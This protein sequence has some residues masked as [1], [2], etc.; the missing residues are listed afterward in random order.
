MLKELLFSFKD[1]FQEKS[2]NPFIWTYFFVWCIRNWPLVYSLF[3][4]DDGTTLQSKVAFIS[5]YLEENPFLSN[6]GYNILYTLALLVVSYILLN[7]SRF[8]VNFSEKTIKPWVYKVTDKGSVVL[9]STYNLLVEQRD[10]TRKSLVAER[11]S[12]SKLEEQIK[13]LEK[14]YEKLASTNQELKA[15]REIDILTIVEDLRKKNLVPFYKTT[16]SLIERKLLISPS[17]KLDELINLH[18][19]EKNAFDNSY[20][21]TEIGKKVYRFLKNS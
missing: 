2:H 1:E 19:I 5:C 21:M 7:I 12:V 16:C 3:N 20:N 11:E 9:K 4:F 8:I 13:N 14:Q 18:T 17:I 6:V 10:E 15:V